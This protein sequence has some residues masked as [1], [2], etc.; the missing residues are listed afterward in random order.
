M[1]PPVSPRAL[2]AR[3][4]DPDQSPISN[5]ELWLSPRSP[6]G[7]RWR[8]DR[9]RPGCR[10]AASLHRRASP[11][12]AACRYGNTRCTRHGESMPRHARPQPDKAC[13]PQPAVAHRVR[14]LTPRKR[15]LLAGMD[16]ITGVLRLF[17]MRCR[18]SSPAAVGLPQY[19][20]RRPCA[21]ARARP[22]RIHAMTTV[23]A[24]I[25]PARRLA[26]PL[27]R[28]PVPLG[29]TTVRQGMRRFALQAPQGQRL[30]ARGHRFG[31]LLVEQHGLHGWPARRRKRAHDH[32][33][34]DAVGAHRNR[35]AR[36]HE[37]SGPGQ[38][39]AHA[40]VACR[41]RALGKRPG[42]VEARGP[43]PD[44][45]AYARARGR[46]LATGCLRH[47]PASARSLRGRPATPGRW[48]KARFSALR[49]AGPHREAIASDDG[50]GRHSRFRARPASRAERPDRS[51]R[52]TMIGRLR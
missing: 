40:D 8:G 44:I 7:I 1:S 38:P 52:H 20:M 19:R 33:P 46:G 21:K 15:R 36:P 27:E 4:I 39:R 48:R 2:Q 47:D 41:N 13:G 12:H 16:A 26:Q 49:P 35:I 5:H 18:P 23:S 25:R 37:T 30:L 14:E 51:G 32:D 24:R 10:S 17:T 31:G 43:Q 3:V 9:H 29:R 28:T 6:H 50:N 34:L 11:I 22:R 45:D 42:P